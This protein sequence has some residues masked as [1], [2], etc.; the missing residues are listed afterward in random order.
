MKTLVIGGAR[1]GKSQYCVEWIK[2]HYKMPCLVVTAEA[3]DEEMAQRIQKH[4]ETRPKHW[5]VIEEPIHLPAC[6]QGIGDGWDVVLVD[7]L[8]LWVSNLLLRFGAAKVLEHI[9][10]L[11]PV[12]KDFQRDL[13]LVTNEVGLG[14]VPENQISRLFRDLAGILNQTLS[15]VCDSVVFVVA[16]IPMRLK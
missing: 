11:V 14:I 12:L 8:T 6:L 7:C 10:A 15:S 3:A 16:G 1:S 9:Q 4:K 2:A 13:F 5:H